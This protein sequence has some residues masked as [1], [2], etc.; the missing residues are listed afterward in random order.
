MVGYLKEKQTIN[1]RKE[2]KVCVKC[3]RKRL[4]KFFEKPT[5]RICNECKKKSKRLKNKPASDRKRLIRELDDLIRDHIKTLPDTCCCCGKENLGYFHPKDNPHGI[6]V[7]H[8]I[9][10]EVITLRWNK[11]NCNPQC[12]GCNKRHQYNQLPY[13]SFMLK[14]YGKDTLD[15]FIAL[16]K[17]FNYTISK[18]PTTI[19]RDIKEQLVDLKKVN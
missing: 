3:D 7:G 5:S 1:N 13:L 16:E 12:S 18:I 4:I 2:K 10:R 8:F 6:Q 17:E 19:L 14:K 9:S 11:K 15:E